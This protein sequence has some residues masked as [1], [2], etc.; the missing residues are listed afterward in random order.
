MAW[1][2]VS[3][4]EQ[5]DEFVSLALQEGANRRALCRRFGI[6]AQ[7]GYKWLRRHLA[8][9][10]GG[11]GDRSRRPLSSPRRS[12]AELEAAVLRLRDAHPAWG[13]RKLVR[14]LE[15]AGIAPPS[16]STVHAILVRHGRIVPPRGGPR[17][18]LRFERAAP[19]ELWQMDFKGWVKLAD[20]TKLHALTVIDDHS[21]YAVCVAACASQGLVPV[22]AQLR[23]TFK[24][25][26]LPQALF[27]D[28]GTPWGDASGRNWTRLKVWLLKLGVQVIHSRP[29]H[30]QGRGKNERFHRTLKAEVY[31]LGLLRDLKHA[32]RAF[33]AWRSV[34]NQQRPHEALDFAVPAER[35]SLSLRPLPRRL[36][37]VVYQT[38]ETIRA[39]SST[40]AYIAFKGRHWKVPEA[41]CG[42]RL[43]IRPAKE[44]HAFG[45]FF[46]SHRIATINLTKPKPVSHVSEQVSPMS[47]G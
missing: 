18:T 3:I 24:R 26:G 41:F 12:A 16:A 4:M 44:P 22:K 7:T 6:S 31:D 1:R 15:R 19:N 40:K 32:Q 11:L 9:E 37:K 33:D 23:R 17:A 30:P 25:Y 20:G 10:A 35:Y 27:V 43:A 46:A 29:F 8:G 45:V 39:V 34:Y 21:R 5:R 14:C 42:E 2:E 36:P 28:N 38:G 47:P 13:A